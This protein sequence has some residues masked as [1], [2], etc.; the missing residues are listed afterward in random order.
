MLDE[1]RAESGESVDG[2]PGVSQAVVFE[3]ESHTL[4]VGEGFDDAADEDACWPRRRSAL[5]VMDFCDIVDVKL[6]DEVFCVG[7]AGHV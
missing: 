4:R 6:E 1:H 3:V 7:E 2:D 5:K